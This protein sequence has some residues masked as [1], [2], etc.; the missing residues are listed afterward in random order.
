MLH[1]IIEPVPWRGGASFAG[2]LRKKAQSGARIKDTFAEWR[3]RSERRKKPWLPQRVRDVTKAAASWKG[4]TVVGA[5]S[6]HPRVPIDLSD[7]CCGRIPKL[8]HQLDM[9][10]V[11]PKTTAPHFLFL[12]L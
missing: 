7:E 2:P 1:R 5:A 9:A 3:A 12:I 4:G 11:W 6:F 10:R 8:L